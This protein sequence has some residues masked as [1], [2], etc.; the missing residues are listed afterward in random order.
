MS[1]TP[2]RPTPVGHSKTDLRRGQLTPAR[3]GPRPATASRPPVA[4]SDA[5]QS[6]L[7][8]PPTPAADSA[9]PP[10]ER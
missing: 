9:P 6:F 8:D 7:L 2:R 1:G 4:T 10:A 3:T 5:E